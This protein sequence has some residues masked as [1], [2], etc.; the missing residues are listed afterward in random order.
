MTI[1][2]QTNIPAEI[3]FTAGAKHAD[4]FNEVTL[5]VVFTDPDGT[6]RRVPA[7]V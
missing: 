7:F 6:P 3:M 1:R 2:T 4:P 5:D